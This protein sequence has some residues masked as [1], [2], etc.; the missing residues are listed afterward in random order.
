MWDEEFMLEKI[1]FVLD[2]TLVFEILDVEMIG[3]R[4][5]GQTVSSL[6]IKDYVKNYAKDFIPRQCKLD[7]VDKNLVR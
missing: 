3:T 5:L 4:A 1:G 6:T 7:I 2:S